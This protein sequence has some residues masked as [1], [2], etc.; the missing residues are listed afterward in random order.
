[1]PF[2][3][4]ALRWGWPA[5]MGDVRSKVQT[6][7]KQVK[8]VK[9]RGRARDRRP[10]KHVITPAQQQTCS[11]SVVYTPKILSSFFF[12][13]SIPFEWNEK[14]LKKKRLNFVI[15]SDDSGRGWRSNST[16]K[17]IKNRTHETIVLF[18]RN[19]VGFYSKSVWVSSFAIV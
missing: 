12:F 9:K 11:P 16:S 8:R 1:M 15:R 18:Y 3:V 19:G 5:Q 14:I 7:K 2:D 13:N 6:V 4:G 10:C 17:E